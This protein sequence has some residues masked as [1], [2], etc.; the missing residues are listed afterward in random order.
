MLKLRTIHANRF[1]TTQFPRRSQPFARKTLEYSSKS[2]CELHLDLQ[3]INEVVEGSNLYKPNATLQ[4]LVLPED[5]KSNIL[6]L[7]DNFEQLLAL[8]HSLP[9]MVSAEDSV[10][11]SLHD[12]L[13]WFSS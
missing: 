9:R 13:E 8:K 1:V 7:V 5:M 12:A 11:I 4:Q 3:E 10:R 2:R 6:A